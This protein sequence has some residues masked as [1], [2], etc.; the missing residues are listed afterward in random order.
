MGLVL[1]DVTFRVERAFGIRVP[2]DW[3]NDLGLV[4]KG[5]KADATLGEYHQYILRLCREQ[6]VPA[7]PQSW[8]ILAQVIEDASGMDR[9]KLTEDTRL[10]RDIAPGG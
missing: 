7:S 2:R 9:E 5:D 10:I 4:W 8:I 6:N 3:H 1:L